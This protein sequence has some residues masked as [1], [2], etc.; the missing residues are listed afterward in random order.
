MLPLDTPCSQDRPWTCDLS[1][2]LSR[3][4]Y[5]SDLH[6]L[7]CFNA[8]NHNTQSSHQVQYSLGWF[9]DVLLF[10][11]CVCAWT[12]WCVHGVHMYIS[13][14]TWGH[15]KRTSGSFITGEGGIPQEGATY[16]V[17]FCASRFSFYFLKIIYF[18][19]GVMYV[20]VCA[21]CPCV[22]VLGTLHI[23]GSQRKMLPVLLDHT[24]PY[25]PLSLNLG[26]FWR[27]ASP[28]DPL[29]SAPA[30]ALNLPAQCRHLCFFKHV[31]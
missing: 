22:Q 12:Y 7:F 17:C 3:W 15:E 29:I 10:C 11:F 27:K 13:E 25:T 2:L 18:C 20:C 6:L 9:V 23:C 31:F 19:E 5:S 30:P 21:V 14:H 26:L 4:G 16:F 28:S 24:P 8:K 1:H